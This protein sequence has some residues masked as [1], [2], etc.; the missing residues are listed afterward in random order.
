MAVNHKETNLQ[1]PFI[2]FMYWLHVDSWL[3]QADTAFIHC[4]TSIADHS[5]TFTRSLECW[6]QTHTHTHTHT[7]QQPT[8]VPVLAD[9]RADRVDSW[10]LMSAEL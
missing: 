10:R 3:L 8:S 5:A 4:V 1:H 7:G 6:H 2:E 9:R